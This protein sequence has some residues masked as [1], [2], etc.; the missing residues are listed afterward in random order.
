MSRTP[1]L[2]AL[3]AA[4][5]MAAG[6]SATARIAK[7]ANATHASASAIRERS[8]AAA[9]DLRGAAPDVPAAAAAMDANVADADAI[10]EATDVVHRALPG[11]RDVVPWWGTFLVWAA[12]AAVLLGA[13]VL[14]W[15]TGA[16]RALRLLLGWIP[17]PVQR[18]ADLAVAALD[19]EQPE[20]PRELVAAERAASPLFDRAYQRA[21]ARA[22]AARGRRRAPNAAAGQ[23]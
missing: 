9:I 1:A 13:A 15:Q 11:T 8:Q 20:G 14:L 19:P 4:V 2:A 7:A 3:V 10:I 6:C 23:P 16:G 5:Q 18:R 17:A 22:A 12:V 21:Q